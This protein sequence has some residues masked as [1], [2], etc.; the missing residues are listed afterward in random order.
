MGKKKQG[1]KNVNNTDLWCAL[2]LHFLM[3]DS[4]NSVPKQWIMDVILHGE[5]EDAKAAFRVLQMWNDEHFAD[6]RKS[7]NV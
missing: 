1:G 6:A 2:M 4:M 3:W 5:Q 7:S